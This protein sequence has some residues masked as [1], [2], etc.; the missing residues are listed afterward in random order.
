MALTV[1]TEHNIEAFRSILPQGTVSGKA[2]LFGWVE[3]DV[4]CAS[5][6][7]DEMDAEYSLVWLWVA[8]VYRCRGIG[9]ALLD[10]VCRFAVQSGG[11]WLSVDYSAEEDWSRI[12]NY[13]LLRRG[14]RL[15]RVLLP[16]YRLQMEAL[17]DA[18]FMKQ[19]EKGQESQSIIPLQ[20]LDAQQRK[21]MIERLE[22]QKKYLVSRADF[23]AADASCSMVLL[24]EGE[25]KGVTLIRKTDDRGD[26]MCLELFYLDPKYITSG[27]ALLR[28]TI[29]AILRQPEGVREIQFTCVSD[30]SLQLTQRLIGDRGREDRRI[31]SGILE[32]EFYHWRRKADV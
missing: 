9:S 20:R 28:Q 12:F 11:N 18:W 21:A 14:F 32:L 23:D 24:K 19:M 16:Q 1:I 25:L 8:P 4:A 2:K 3:E 27:M 30:I 5:A 17:G 15:E 13:L 31:F 10:A 22:Y 29:Q 26:S 7:L 6:V